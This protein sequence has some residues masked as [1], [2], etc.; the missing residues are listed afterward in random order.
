MKDWLA[1]VFD[2]DHPLS[3]HVDFMKDGER[4]RVCTADVRTG[5]GE[6]EIWGDDGKPEIDWESQRFKTEPYS[7]DTIRLHRD[8]SASI[9]EAFALFV[10]R[11][12]D[13]SAVAFLA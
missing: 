2:K 3:L 7:F 13:E 8:A 10:K 11:W 6:R 4:L 12:K 9:R 1:P 5:E